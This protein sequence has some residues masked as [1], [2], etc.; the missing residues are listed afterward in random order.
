MKLWLSVLML[1]VV[2]PAAAHHPFTQYYDASKRQVIT[3]VVAELHWINPH[4]MLV[5]EVSNPE[6]RKERWGFE[7]FPPHTFSAQGIDLKKKLQP[8]TK[9]TITGWSARDSKARVLAGREI[10]FSDKST[11]L[12]G[13]TPEEGDRWQ[14]VPGPCS[15]KYPEIR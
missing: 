2:L 12:F 14:C 7:G 11:M 1:A 10:T 3:G 4:V 6:G 9:I 15:F 5:V 8:G 13:P